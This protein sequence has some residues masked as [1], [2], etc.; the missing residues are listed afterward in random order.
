VASAARRLFGKPA[1]VGWGAGLVTFRNG[2]I[3]LLRARWR[4]LTVA[5]VA[6][7]L[8]LF[9]VLLLALRHM[10]VSASQVSWIEALGAFGLVRLLT[11]LPITPG[12]LGVVELGLVAALVVAGGERAPVVAA[13]LVFRFLT[14][15]V[16]V[17]IGAL[18]YAGWRLHLR[19]AADRARRKVS[20]VPA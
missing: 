14:L 20:R 3:G 12:G 7:H 6:S 4:R 19:R 8:S 9:V 16:Q 18:S 17:P 15:V 10:D 2:A 11:A 13:V 1:V 5:T